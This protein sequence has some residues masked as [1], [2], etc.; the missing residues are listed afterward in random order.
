M[1]FHP[2]NVLVHPALQ[3]LFAAFTDIAGRVEQAVL[4]MD[5]SFG[6]AKRRDI[7]VS[8]NVAQMLLRHGRA[9]GAD[10]RA[11]HACGLAGPG[12]LAIRARGVINRV[13]EH[14]GD[15]T[16]VFSGDEQQAL[17]RR[18]FGLQPLDGLGWVRVVVL[19]VQRQVA[20][21]HLLE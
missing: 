18:D 15:R 20:D 4:R 21:L 13:L 19:V 16:V 12:T 11:Q 10:R 9:G 1:P 7:Q 5:E 6:L 17:S 2:G 14:T 8:E 3:K